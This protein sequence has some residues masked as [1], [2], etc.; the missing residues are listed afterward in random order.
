MKTNNIELSSKEFELLLKGVGILSH[1][2]G[3]MGDFVDDKYKKKSE[4]LDRLENVLCEKA[5]EFNLKNIVKEFEG[6]KL[7]DIE[8]DWYNKL[9]E[10]LKEFE[11]YSLF[12][13]LSNKLAWRDFHRKHSKEEIEEMRKRNGGY[14]G[15]DIYEFEKKY[16]DEF[17]DH[18]YERLEIKE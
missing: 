7:I 5:S 12:D 8:S 2:Y 11:E 16:Y 15:V 1:M 17:N 13:T 10:D 6:R 3:L 18:E 9:I 4:E 14:F